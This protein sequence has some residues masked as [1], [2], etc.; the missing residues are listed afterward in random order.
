MGHEELARWMS[1]ALARLG[2]MSWRQGIRILLKTGSTAPVGAAKQ[3]IG[4][5][6]LGGSVPNGHARGTSTLSILLR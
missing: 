1:K 6:C 5:Q 2:Q 4:A 3:N